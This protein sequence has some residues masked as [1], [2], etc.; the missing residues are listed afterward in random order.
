MSPLKTHNL[1][2]PRIGAHRELKIALEKYW[3]KE[4]TLHELL[5]TAKEIRK[6]HWILQ[7]EKG[8]DFI[9]SNDFSLYDHVLD[10]IAMV[11]AVPERFLWEG[12]SVHTPTYFA[13]ARGTTKKEE[14]QTKEIRPLERK[15]W[16]NTP[17]FSVV[18]EF[19]KEQNFSLASAKPFLEFTEAMDLG[20]RTVPVLLGPISFLLLGKTMGEPFSVLSLLPKL[21]PIYVEAFKRLD[22]LGAQMIQIDEPLLTSD[23]EEEVQALYQET[24]KTLKTAIPKIKLMVAVYGGELQ[25]N[26]DTF[27]SLP[28]DTLHYDAVSGQDE[29]ILLLSQFPKEKMLSL[30][31]VD[32]QNI[33]KNDYALSISLIKKAKLILGDDR[34]IISPS[35][36]LLHVPLT[37]A[38]ENAMD[39]EVK[40]WMAF[41]TEKLQ[42][43]KTLSELID[44][45]DLEMDPRYHENESSIQSRKNSPRVRHIPETPN[46]ELEMLSEDWEEGVS[47]AEEEKTTLP[48]KLCIPPI[49]HSVRTLYQ[50]TMLVDGDA[51]TNEKEFF[52]ESLLQYEKWETRQIFHLPEEVEIHIL[53][54]GEPHG[55]NILVK[56]KNGILF[57]ENAWIQSHGQKC[58]KPSLL[59]GDITQKPEVSSE[60]L[61]HDTPLLQKEIFTG[62]ISTLYESFVRNDQPQ[63][64]T[65]LQIAQII[66]TEIENIENAAEKMIEIH[67]PALWD[68]LPLKKE[69][70]KKYVEMVAN[71]WQVI[72]GAKSLENPE[73]ESPLL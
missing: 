62:P 35:C 69:E 11:G 21:L 16:M 47:P 8:I 45:E 39:A 5:D 20:I 46:S 15:T 34:I 43:L 12:G 24:Y 18:P 13:M 26:R 65:A 29:V 66:R 30:G 28:V 53:K 68:L 70:Q 49:P 27:L 3:K 57:P 36:S 22:S 37:L 1:G 42:E 54:N 23:L 19:N 6:H 55:R 72:F 51:E 25:E 44:Q 32:G 17:Y 71:A 33:W 52:E 14:F 59:F 50:T 7:K 48:K 73:S 67:E 2:F 41:A 63:S 38:N 56:N 9:P 61:A 40:S 31:I 10:T 4:G 58:I 64:E 60:D